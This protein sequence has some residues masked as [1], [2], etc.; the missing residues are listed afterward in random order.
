MVH[1]TY[2]SEP[3]YYKG[4][5]R[6]QFRQSNTLYKCINNNTTEMETGTFSTENYFKQHQ[7]IGRRRHAVSFRTIAFV[8]LFFCYFK[9]NSLFLYCRLYASSGNVIANLYVNKLCPE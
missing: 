3:I 6:L 4:N 5:C 9:I 1:R 2:P 8:F 7:K